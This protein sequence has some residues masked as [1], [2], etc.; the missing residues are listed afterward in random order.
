VEWKLASKYDIYRRFPGGGLIFW[1]GNWFLDMTLIEDFLAEDWFLVWK[2]ASRYDI[3]R[4]LP[5]GELIFW[6]GS[7]VLDITLIE[8]FLVVLDYELNPI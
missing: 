5:N 1:C 2:L 8:D 6:C 7:W 3:Y 4:R